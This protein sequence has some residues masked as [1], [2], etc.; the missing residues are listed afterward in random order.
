[1]YVEN[2]IIRLNNINWDAIGQNGHKKDME[3]GIEFLK[4]MAK[5]CKKNNIT[6]N[7]PFMTDLPSFF[8]KKTIDNVLLEQCNDTVKKIIKNPSFST[9]VVNYY[10]RA[11]LLKDEKEKKIDCIYV[12]EPIILLF[13]KG[14]NF[15]YKERG[16]SFINSG[17]IPLT[18]WFEKFCKI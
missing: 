10:L 5:F 15:I 8:G 1:M 4:K 2:A 9:S 12:Y 6:P 3:L 17:L 14:G 16:M 7:L 11:S 18:N 13:E